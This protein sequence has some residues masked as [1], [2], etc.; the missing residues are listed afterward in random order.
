MILDG[1]GIADHPE[2]S[3]ISKAQTPNYDNYLKKFPNA[4]LLTHGEHVGLPEGQ[5]GNSEVGHM[6]I[7]S[8]RVVMQELAKINF[9]I[10]NNSFDKD[11]VLSKKIKKSIRNNK[12]IH[13]IG[14]V[15]DGGVHSHIDHLKHI[16]N[17][18]DQM[19]AKNVFIHAFT[20][21]RDVDPKSGINFI[22]ELIEFTKNKSAELA[23]LCGRYYSM[24]RDQRWERIKKAYELLVNG[25]GEP[26]KD[27]LNTIKMSYEKGITDEFINPIVLEKNGKPITQVL[28]GDLVVFFNFRTDRGRQLTEALTQKNIPDYGMVKVDIDLVTMTVYNDDFVNIDSIYHKEILEETLGQ[29][30]S[31]NNK[32]Q[33]RIAE[34]EKYP[35]VTFF[36]NGGNEKILKDEKRIMCNSPKV[37]TYD[38]KPE[39][40]AHEIVSKIIPEI[41]TWSAEFI[42]LNF[43]N[44]DM[45]GHT[46]NFSAAV[47]ACEVVDD[48][49]GKVVDKCIKNNYSIIIIADHGNSDV[50]INIDGSANTAHTTNPVPIIVIDK[51]VEKVEDGILADIAPT[52]LKLLDI[53]QPKLM[54]GKILI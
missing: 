27:V 37:A 40:S 43:A 35:H 38:L 44:P 23:T 22:T 34:T 7:G 19:N 32:K 25:V 33:I 46:G 11:K 51:K 14:L 16:I 53:K 13:I 12:N 2:K 17:M 26:T 41:E 31:M 6:N 18:T 47:S 45:V 4:K 54:T 52:V 36:F 49:M 15:S 20:D 3:A 8:G 28:N 48:C 9:D 42:C 5:M 30:L 10:K 1:W 39:M 50:M 29:V 24:D 21:G